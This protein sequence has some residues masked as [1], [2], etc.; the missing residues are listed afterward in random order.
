MSDIIAL[1]IREEH[2]RHEALNALS[3][4]CDHLP[5]DKIQ[6]VATILR[7]LPAAS[8]D[9]LEGYAVLL[10]EALSHA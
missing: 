7:T 6:T 10:Q 8:P 1:M 5:S 2:A 3:S 4:A 9:T